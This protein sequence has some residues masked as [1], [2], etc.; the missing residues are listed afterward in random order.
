MP[1]G[2]R[3]DS[4][5]ALPLGRVGVGVDGKYSVRFAHAAATHPVCCNRILLQTRGWYRADDDFT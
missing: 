5:Y 1:F 2:V 4:V 3:L